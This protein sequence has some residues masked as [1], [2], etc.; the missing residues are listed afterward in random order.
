MRE[1]AVVA[2]LLS[3]VVPAWAAS[4]PAERALTD[5]HSI[6]SATNPDARPVPIDDLFYTRSTYTPAWSHDGRWVA[7]STNLTGRANIYKIAAAGGWPMQMVQSDDRQFFPV[8]SPD[9]KWIVYQQDFGGSEVWDLFAIPATGGEALNLTNSVDVSEEHPAFSRD[10]ALVGFTTKAR[11][12]S[13]RDIA[14][15]DWKT[16]QVRHLT[17][18]STKDH[19]WSIAA[20][21]ADG[22]SL[23]ANRINAAFTD[24][25]VYRIDVASGKAENL[26]PHEGDRM[27]LA[28]DVS[29][30][31]RT[32]PHDE[33]ARRIR[34]R[35]AA[36]RGQTEADV[37]HR[38]TMAVLR[39]NVRPRR[40]PVHVH[41]QSRWHRGHVRRDGHRH[42]CEGDDAGWEHV[43]CRK[44]ERLLS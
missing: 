18:E 22:T 4:G 26:T 27:Y 29:A 43:A 31:G 6:V 25:A 11:S 20:W 8:F 13:A 38:H 37:G 32:P 7:F 5:P 41:D 42:A 1:L 21:N 23:Y 24:A 39:G 30:D 2:S 19:V 17:H 9:D 15:L 14:V 33:R 10:G 36:R 28:N 12:S 34:Q 44:S 40:T 3:M 35:R 16:R